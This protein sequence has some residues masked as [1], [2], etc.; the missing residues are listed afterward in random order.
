M[1]K[2]DLVE[3]QILIL[4]WKIDEIIA[5]ERENNDCE[6]KK[7]TN[8]PLLSS[9]KMNSNQD[10]YSLTQNKPKKTK[11][12]QKFKF[13]EPNVKLCKITVLLW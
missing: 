12:V 5:M 4:N 6:N 3:Y 13:G 10:F 8:C 1:S 9:P 11:S 7:K 2:Y